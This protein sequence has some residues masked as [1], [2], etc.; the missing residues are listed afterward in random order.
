M[1]ELEL[2]V[3][4]ITYKDP[5]GLEGPGKTPLALVLRPLWL[6]YKRKKF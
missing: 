3:V 2:S 1:A 5:A 6:A 4:T